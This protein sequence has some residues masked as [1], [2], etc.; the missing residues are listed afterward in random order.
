MSIIPLCWFFSYYLIMCRRTW[1]RGLLLFQACELIVY[2]F[3]SVCSFHWLNSHVCALCLFSFCLQEDCVLRVGTHWTSPTNNQRR[4]HL[5]NP[6][7]PES[8]CDQM[9]MT[10]FFFHIR[11]FKYSQKWFIEAEF[12]EQFSSNYVSIF[13]VLF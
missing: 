5:S 12:S 10:I 2:V 6:F 7:I 9:K 3:G 8:P 11:P 1:L 4:F 13:F